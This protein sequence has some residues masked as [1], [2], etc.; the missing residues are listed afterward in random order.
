MKRK[1]GCSLYR[2]SVDD[3]SGRATTGP[4][5]DGMVIAERQLGLMCRRTVVN[6]W[7]R[8][9]IVEHP[10]S[11]SR[12]RKLERIVQKYHT[13]NL[14]GDWLSRCYLHGAARSVAQRVPAGV[15]CD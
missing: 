2:V 6:Y 10:P 15:A 8:K 1:R 3:P 4:I 12:R 14:P 5:L 11:A 13:D 9:L 7:R